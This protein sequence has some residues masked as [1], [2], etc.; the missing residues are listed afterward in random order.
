MDAE[1]VGEGKYFGIRNLLV[2]IW[3]PFRVREV[4]T[5]SEHAGKQSMWRTKE[6]KHIC[7]KAISEPRG[8]CLMMIYILLQYT[9]YLLNNSAVDVVCG[10]E[11]NCKQ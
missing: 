6:A 3:S 10:R 1:S 11:S 8:Y 5:R 2:S 7:P 9:D 4:L